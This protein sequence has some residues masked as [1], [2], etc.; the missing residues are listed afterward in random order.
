MVRSNLNG[1][2]RRI[3]SFKNALF[4]VG[5]LVK[6]QT[7]AKI[8]ALA[9]M[10]VTLLGGYMR[11]SSFEWCWIVAAM[12]MV[13]CAEALNTAIELLADA[14]VPYDHPLVKQAKDVA[15]AAVLLSAIGAIL[16]GGLVFGPHLM[17]AMQ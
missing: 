11:L 14:V 10:L 5:L 12:V 15:A 9:T 6:S 3:A 17:A 4:G 16:I 2:N 8:H 1:V 7:N 13:W